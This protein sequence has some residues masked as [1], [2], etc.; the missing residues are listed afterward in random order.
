MKHTYYLHGMTCN[1]CRNHVTQTLSKVEGVTNVSVDL[2][3][4]QA[5]IE[6]A[7]HIPI[8]T[9]QKAMEQDGDR[10]SIYK[11]G[12]QHK[13]LAAKKEKPKGKGTGTFYCPMH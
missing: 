2:E 1:G 7:S 9:L 8:E 11:L 12:E 3:N 13:A 6:M 5:T 10:Y 4:A